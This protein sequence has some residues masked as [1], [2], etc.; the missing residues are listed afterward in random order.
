MKNLLNLI[1]LLLVVSCTDKKNS[2]DKDS[3]TKDTTSILKEE[4]PYMENYENKKKM[5]KLL[6]SA[7]INGDTL[8]YQEAFKDYM[9]SR[10]LQEFLYYSIKMA[11]IHKYGE[12]YFD[13]Y[14]IINLNDK[15]NGYLSEKDNDLSLF[16]LLKA[17]ELDNQTAKDK[18]TDLFV[19]KNLK[20]PSS[21]SI[22]K[23]N[24]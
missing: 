12:A 13:T 14:Y 21:S 5:R 3:L 10:H 24:R 17:Y 6:D 15:K 18:I 1:I 23:E 20:I 16:Y 2:I 19:K 8:S 4:N 7:I 9:V 11:K 22:I